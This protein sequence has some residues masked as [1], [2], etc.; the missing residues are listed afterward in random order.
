MSKI[1]SYLKNTVNSVKNKFKTEPKEEEPS[2]IEEWRIKVDRD[3]RAK[4]A[5]RN[6]EIPESTNPENPPAAPVPATEGEGESNSQKIRSESSAK[7][8]FNDD[9]SDS[10]GDGGG[11]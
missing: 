3:T 10:G 4:T 5:L 2:Y 9:Y 1:N 7:Q 11:D 6:R 8:E